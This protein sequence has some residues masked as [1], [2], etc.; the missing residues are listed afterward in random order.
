MATDSD[1]GPQSSFLRRLG[2]AFRNLVIFAVVVAAATGGLYAASLLNSRTWSLEVQGGQLIV[3]RGKMLPIGTEPFQPADPLLAEAYAP[4]DLNGNTALAVVGQ[5]FEDRDE[6]D[7][8]LFSVIELLAKP[9]VASDLK[10]DLDIGVALVKRAE[11]LRGLTEQQRATLGT[12]KAEVAYFLAKQRIDDAR[13]QLDEALQQLKLAADADA[14]HKK[15]ATQMLL[16]VEPQ[17]K[18]LSDTLR[19]AVQGLPPPPPVAPNPTPPPA[20]P[21]PADVK[22]AEDAAAD[23]GAPAETQKPAPPETDGH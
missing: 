13:K 18:S 12:L 14:R 17:V 22:P 21:K 9:R 3:T 10:R 11:A 4:L 16:A 6:L 7:R 19:A 5:K 20:D 15:D 8:A 2:R 1:A 23:A